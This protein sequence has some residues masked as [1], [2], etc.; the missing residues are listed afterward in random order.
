MLEDRVLVQGEERRG[1]HG[2][3]VGVDLGRMSGEPGR[4]GRGLRARVDRDREAD[5]ARLDETLADALALGRREQEAFTGR[6]ADER[7]V[8]PSRSEEVDEGT[9]RVFV[10][11]GAA[12]RERGHGRG[13]G[14]SEHGR[15]IREGSDRVSGRFPRNV[16]KV[17]DRRV[18]HQAG[19][20]VTR[21]SD[22]AT[23]QG[24][25]RML[26]PL[27]AG[28]TVA[29]VF[30]AV[31]S[32]VLTAAGPDGMRLSHQRTGAWIAVVY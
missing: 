26:P 2:N 9:D 18:R 19:G 24:L 7:A 13:D 14:P 16:R 20:T 22:P 27:I 4:V 25:R 29:I 21:V 10:D 28:F 6:P 17:Y 23:A 12:G 5:G 31:L 1:D 3:S 8:E 11:V 15:T 32:I 30:A